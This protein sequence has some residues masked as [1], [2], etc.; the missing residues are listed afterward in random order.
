MEFNEYLDEV[1]N[2]ARTLGYDYKTVAYFIGDIRDCF[3]QGMS[4]EECI[5]KEF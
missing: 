1:V 3:E 4:V 5:E 2:Q